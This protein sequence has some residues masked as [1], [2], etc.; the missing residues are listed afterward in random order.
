MLCA[1]DMISFAHEAGHF[2]GLDHIFATDGDFC[3]DTPWY[4]YNAYKIAAQG[5]IEVVRNKVS[6][7]SFWSD[8]I[9]D[10]EYG[11]MSGVTPDQ[12][13]RI[14]YT[15]QHAYFIPGEAGKSAPRARSFGQKRHFAGKPVK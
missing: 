10:Y 7:E 4:D 12:L 1:N 15:L 9:M 13:S 3:D 11:Y 2:L 5:G 8:N 6:G 14:R